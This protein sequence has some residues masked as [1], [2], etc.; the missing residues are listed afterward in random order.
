MHIGTGHLDGL[1]LG[2]IS[3]NRAST[4]Y[5]P[6]VINALLEKGALLQFGT[7]MFVVKTREDYM[8]ISKMV[9]KQLTKHQDII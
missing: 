5:M 9:A 1:K 6:K 3:T 4:N 7:K 8:E 2:W